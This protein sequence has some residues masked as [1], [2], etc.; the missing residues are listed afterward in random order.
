MFHLWA[1]ERSEKTWF[2]TLKEEIQKPYIHELKKFLQ[3][4][5]RPVKLSIRLSSWYLMLFHKRRMKR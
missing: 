5:E 2:E 3:S 1:L 4:G